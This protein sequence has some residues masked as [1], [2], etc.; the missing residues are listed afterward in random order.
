MPKV[1]PSLE[2]RN[3]IIINHPRFPI[4]FTKKFKTLENIERDFFSDTNF[5]FFEK[6]NPEDKSIL[7]LQ[8]NNIFIVIRGFTG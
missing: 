5:E 4:S 1:H 8:M 3:H 6:L 2:I 7:Q